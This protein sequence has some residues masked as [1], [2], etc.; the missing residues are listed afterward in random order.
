ME[1]NVPHCTGMAFSE[2]WIWPKG[3][4]LSIFKEPN[5]VVV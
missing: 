2:E 4:A 5:E 1:R 3:L